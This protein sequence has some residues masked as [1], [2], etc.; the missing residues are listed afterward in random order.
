MHPVVGPPPPEPMKNS[1]AL[2]RIIGIR[3]LAL[4]AP[5]FLLLCFARG[6]SADDVHIFPSIGPNHPKSTSDT[7]PVETQTDS[8]PLNNPLRVDVDVVLV[9]VTVSDSEN[10]PVTTLKKQDFALFEEGE[11]KEIRYFSAEEAPLSVAILL[12]VSKSMSDKVDTERA[13][14]VEFFNNAHPDDEYFAITF[15][16]RPREVASATQSINELETKLTAI[17][18]GG[19]TAM[20]DAVYLAV[21]KLR[22]AR[23]TRKAIVIFS[24]G[25]DNA[26][27]YTLREIKNM[28]QE[29]DVQIY[30]I[31]LFDTF[32]FGTLEEKL[33]K[34]WLS[35]ITDA[36]GGRTITVDNSMKLPEAAATISRE[37]RNQYTLGYRPDGPNASKWR[38]I[39][40][41][42]TQPD[43]EQRLH[44]FYRKG[45]SAPARTTSSK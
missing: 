23:Y 42:V 41:R 7:V 16:D 14:I 15:S 12:D 29:S 10:R 26:S 25:G 43:R 44:A 22:S 32:F 19:P 27:R 39:K 18:P 5:T 24:D 11:R 30:A 31:G 13:A 33:G 35:E 28:V 40:V 1:P 21:S 34:L 6:Q 2:T 17:E 36:T 3:F 20:L 38:K 8:T 4:C 45:Y 9:P 37:L